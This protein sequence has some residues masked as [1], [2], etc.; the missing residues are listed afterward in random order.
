M[1]AEIYSH[2]KIIGTSELKITDESMGVIA[3][4]F[5]PTENYKEIRERIWEVNPVINHRELRLNARLENGYFIFPLGGFLINDI[6]DLPNEEIIFEAAG[7]YRHLIEDNFLT[8]PPKERI[9]EPWEFIS[10]GQ[11]MAFEDELK[12]E[13]G[14][15][16]EIGVFNSHRLSE[17][18]FSAMACRNDNI[19]FAI[20][21]KGVN[22]FSYAMIHLTWKGELEKDDS[23]PI[24]EFYEDFDCFL[25]YRMYPDKND[26]E[27]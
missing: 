20:H 24:T 9:F 8:H 16:D 18:E 11:K 2:K 27:D 6:E 4:R 1:E 14:T 15:S 17:F 26:W 13:I 10:I 19:L 7:V 22:E 23:F 21:K 12:K 3:G 25:N 5:I